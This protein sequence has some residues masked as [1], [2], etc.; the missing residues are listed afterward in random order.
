ML[1]FRIFCVVGACFDTHTHT[2]THTHLVIRARARAH[3][4]THTHTRDRYD[5]KCEKHMCRKEE[6]VTGKILVHH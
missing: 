1:L 3:T 5:L 6:E 2:Y 4:H